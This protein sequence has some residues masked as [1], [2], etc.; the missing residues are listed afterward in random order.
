MQ[1]LSSKDV[2]FVGYTYKNFEIVQDANVPGIGKFIL[3]LLDLHYTKNIPVP[4][5]AR[6]GVYYVV[7]CLLVHCFE[8]EIGHNVVYVVVL[9]C[10]YLLISRAAEL[11]KK[12]KPKRPSIKT[13]FG[14]FSFTPVTNP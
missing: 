3:S 13:L 5:L 1:M 14:E 8:L 2:N 6:F 11:K 4:R 12:G 10:A 9:V 7:D